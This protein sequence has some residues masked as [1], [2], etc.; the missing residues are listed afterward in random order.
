MIITSKGRPVHEYGFG[1][2]V[3]GHDSEVVSR[4]YYR[5]PQTAS[6]GVIQTAILTGVLTSES[7][8]S[9]KPNMHTINTVNAKSSNPRVRRQ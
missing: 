1:K 3:E 2:K 7:Q 4:A 6:F 8:L 9:T 5:K